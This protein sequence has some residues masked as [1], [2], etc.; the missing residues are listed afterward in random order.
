MF[1][2]HGYG[3]N[4]TKLKRAIKIKNATYLNGFNRIGDDSYCWYKYSVPL[5]KDSWMEPD[6][7]VIIPVEPER[8][9]SKLASLNPK[10]L[11]GF[12]EGARFCL[13]Y[14]RHR[15]LSL[16]VLGILPYSDLDYQLTESPLNTKCIF[17]LSKND[18]VVPQVN[19]ERMKKL[20]HIPN[21]SF[22]TRDTRVYSA[23]RG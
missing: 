22:M 14:A 5:T 2:L 8:E 16:L 19:V 10:I 23:E 18:T 1:C 15:P 17:I 6:Q 4:S 11:I 13:N 21:S 7:N 9:Y 3:Q 20:F 12:S